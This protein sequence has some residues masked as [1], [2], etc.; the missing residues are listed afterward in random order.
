MTNS[1]Q[2]IGI[3]GLGKIARFHADNIERLS[4]DHDVALAAGMDVDPE[5]RQQFTE[6]YDVP[7][8][9][10]VDEL[11]AD[12]DAVIVTT[13]NQ[14]HEEYAVATLE[15]DRHVL[16]EK[17]LAHTLSSAERIA[18][19]ARSSDGIC[20]VGFHKRYSNPVQVLQSAIAEGRFG[21]LTHIEANF[22]RRRGIPGRGTWFTDEAAAGGGALIDIG[23]HAIDLAM[24]LLDFPTVEEVTGITRS[25]FGSRE[26][27]TYLDMWGED[28]GDTFDV[29]DSASAFVRCRDETT[30]S[31]E[32]AWASNRPPTKEFIVQGTE[33]GATI[34]L[35]SG[36]L[37]IHEVRD[38][39]ADHF[40]DTQITTAPVDDHLPEDRLFVEAIV[41]GAQPPR[42]TPETALAV[43]RIIDGIYR[44]SRSDK[45][46][47]LGDMEIPADD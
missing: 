47:A 39:G 1:K 20:M 2:S 9:E 46:V 25:H 26:E 34:D 27:Y 16:V 22:V 43:Q 15:A 18:Q 37:T 19:A 24:Y 45:A 14:F 31:L 21:E 40:A 12:V 5:A 29:D 11:L 13:P 10:T 36:D 7:T 32:V 42:N 41:D 3:V 35:A 30:I 6:E 38:D 28:S 23:T 17:P 4:A 8:V 33:A 44:S